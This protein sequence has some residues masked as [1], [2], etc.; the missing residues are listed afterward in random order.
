MCRH[1]AAR[2]P[3]ETWLFGQVA[4]SQPARYSARGVASAMQPEQLAG[5]TP[6]LL[7]KLG[8]SLFF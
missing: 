6:K 1:L 5:R 3:N 4:G 8:G 2:P 7:R